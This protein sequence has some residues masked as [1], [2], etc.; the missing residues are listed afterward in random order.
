MRHTNTQ[1][2]RKV[3]IGQSKTWIQ[4]RSR[5]IIWKLRYIL[6]YSIPRHEKKTKRSQCNHSNA[7]IT[8]SMYGT[9]NRKGAFFLPTSYQ[10]ESWVIHMHVVV[11]YS[12]FTHCH[13]AFRLF[14]YLQKALLLLFIR[15]I[16]VKY[17]DLDKD[18]QQPMH[19]KK[20]TNIIIVNWI[21]F[22]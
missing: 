3:N 21:L 2:Y 10:L 4:K 14:L 11:F 6:W 7:R 19:L 15:L 13:F 1:K 16:T 17:K 12:H 22:V 8:Y 18:E 5:R 20:K 9:M